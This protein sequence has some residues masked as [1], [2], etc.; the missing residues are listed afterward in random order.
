MT[1]ETGWK[2]VDCC[3]LLRPLSPP[4]ICRKLYPW[5]TRVARGFRCTALGEREPWWMDE[6]PWGRE[7][8]LPHWRGGVGSGLENENATRSR[9]GLDQQKTAEGQGQ[10][11]RPPL[12]ISLATRVQTILRYRV[13][14]DRAPPMRE[15]FLGCNNNLPGCVRR[16][17]KWTTL[18]GPRSTVDALYS[19]NTA[20]T[21]P[22]VRKRCKGG[23]M[24]RNPSPNIRKARV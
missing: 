10:S 3:T 16:V 18:V 24:S 4:A 14:V 2:I 23:A 20:Q 15:S 19:K 13:H 6:R 12:Q 1:A 11:N 8:N 7:Q 17:E 9:P 21:A 5:A 22:G